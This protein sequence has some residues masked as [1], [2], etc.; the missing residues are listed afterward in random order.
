MGRHTILLVQTSKSE[1]T[2]KWSDFEETSSALAAICQLFEEKLRREHP[3]MKEITY[4]GSD[5]LKFVDELTDLAIL[6]YLPQDKHYVP[7]GKT[8]I[9]E[10]LIN[11]LKRQL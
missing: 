9:K 10:Q 6:I 3:N 11:H 4:D 8:W 5:L 1:N 2:K 7:Y